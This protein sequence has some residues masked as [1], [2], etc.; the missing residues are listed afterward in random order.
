MIVAEQV[1]VFPWLS[2]TVSVS[3]LA[4]RLAQVNAVLV[5]AKVLMVQLSVDALG[6]PMV[7]S[8]REEFLQNTGEN[9]ATQD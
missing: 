3:R 6:L 8:I 4:P 9:P 7:Q 2:V 1:D 5:N